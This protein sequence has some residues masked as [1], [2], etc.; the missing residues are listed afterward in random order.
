MYYPDNSY[1]NINIYNM[2]MKLSDFELS[3]KYYENEYSVLP[4][5]HAQQKGVQK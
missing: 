3:I 5:S 1:I 2:D 4:L